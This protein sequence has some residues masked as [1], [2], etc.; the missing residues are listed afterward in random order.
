MLQEEPAYRGRVECI[1][2]IRLNLG[3]LL[4]EEVTDEWQVNEKRLLGQA[5]IGTQ[6]MSVTPQ[7]FV[8][9][10]LGTRIRRHDRGCDPTFRTEIVE[11]KSQGGP[12]ISRWVGLPRKRARHEHLDV[13]LAEHSLGDLV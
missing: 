3:G 4:G 12:G 7:Q 1:R 11:P 13:A 6:M 8:C 9:T 10:G 2:R 5:A